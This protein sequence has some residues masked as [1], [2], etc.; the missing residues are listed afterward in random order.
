MKKSEVARIRDDGGAAPVLTFTR[1]SRTVLVRCYALKKV[2]LPRLLRILILV[3]LS[4]YRVTFRRIVVELEPRWRQDALTK[5]RKLSLVLG[6]VEDSRS[7]ERRLLQHLMI[8]LR[9]IRTQIRSLQSA[10][11]GVANLLRAK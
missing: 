10:R 9:M 2:V 6:E 1:K 7:R 4:F 5:R 11:V 3:I 8:S